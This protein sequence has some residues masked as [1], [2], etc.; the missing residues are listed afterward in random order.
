[1]MEEDEVPSIY[2]HA[3]SI[4]SHYDITMTHHYDTIQ[5]MLTFAILIWRPTPTLK[6]Q[7]C[8]A[9]PRQPVEAVGDNRDLWMV[10]CDC[11][12]QR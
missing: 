3:F 1:M 2:T 11:A 4:R 7:G 9:I 10:N 5:V 12:N 8:A 6:V